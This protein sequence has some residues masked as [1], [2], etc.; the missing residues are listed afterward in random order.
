MV[1]T[2]AWW[3]LAWTRF[4][5]FA[6]LQRY[7]FFPL[8]FGFI[9][10]VNALT[11]RR[12]GSCWMLRAPR[13][14]LGLF[15]ASAVFWWLFEWLNRFVQTWHYLSV[16]DFGPTGYVA[17]GTLCFSTVLPAVAAVSEWLQ[18]HPRW[19]ARCAA[20]P[21]WRWLNRRTSGFV[22]LTVG[23]A[24][25]VLTGARPQEFYPALWAAPLLLALGENVLTRR[26]GFWSEVAAGDWRRAASWAAAALICGFFWELW[27][28]RSAAKWIYTVPH[29]DRWHVFEMPLLGYAGY[30]PFGLE[31]LAF[32]ERIVRKSSA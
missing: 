30:I 28:V 21:A 22:L 31:C 20:G 15:V 26:P 9:V 18:S 17:N 4:S 27:N 25:L 3:V 11:F 29:V 12:A 8:W 32:V 24:A 16:E 14:W 5:W 23:I 1:W 6:P 19:R 2:L 13:S 7:T 10:G